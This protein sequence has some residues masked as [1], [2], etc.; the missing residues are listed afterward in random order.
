LKNTKGG[1]NVIYNKDLDEAE[2]LFLY[3]AN[4][5]EIYFSRI[6]PLVRNLHKYYKKGIFDRGKAEKAFQTI[7][8]EAAK[9]YKKE[10]ASEN[11]YDKTFNVN[12]RKIA[13]CNLVSYYMENIEKGDL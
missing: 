7:A 11:A 4:T 10:F 2:D 9:M 3:A 12:T 1:E 13:A 6:V 5:R 8:A